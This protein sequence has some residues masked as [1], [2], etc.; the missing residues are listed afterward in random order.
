MHTYSIAVILV[1]VNCYSVRLTAYVSVV[2]S[3]L[4]VLAIFFIVGVGIITVMI[5]KSF[6]DQLL[7]PF[8]SLEGHEPSTTSVAVALYGVLWAY[9]G[10]YAILTDTSCHAIFN[11]RS[12]GFLYAGMSLIM[13]SRKQIT[14][15]GEY[16]LVYQ[17]IIFSP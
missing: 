15:R 7:R 14:L 11:Q 6:P 2:F 17:C 10:W 1:L 5:R 3:G 16:T 13:L 12:F 4:K 9:D 8:E